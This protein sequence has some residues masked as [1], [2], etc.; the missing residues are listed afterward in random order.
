MSALV[1]RLVEPNEP[2]SFDLQ[3]CGHSVREFPYV[4]AVDLGED[5]YAPDTWEPGVGKNQESKTSE[6]PNKHN[7][8]AGRRVDTGRR[9]R[10][11]TACTI[12]RRRG[13]GIQSHCVV[14][15][16]VRSALPAACDHLEVEPAKKDR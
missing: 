2:A 6:H 11:T 16:T 9:D 12:G 10:S 8:S 3:S 5:N 15:A 14:G 13:R 4:D 1:S 7:R